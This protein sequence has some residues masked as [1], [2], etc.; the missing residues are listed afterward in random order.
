[1]HCFDALRRQY[2]YDNINF[3]VVLPGPIDTEML[4]G[5]GAHELPFIHKA[6][7]DA[8]YI[9]EQVFAGKKQIEPSWFY[10]V[11]LRLLSYL[12]DSLLIKML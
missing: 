6:E 9:V 1:M 2:L 11:Y 3:S 4:K 10:S 8:R 5:P 7:D 12:P